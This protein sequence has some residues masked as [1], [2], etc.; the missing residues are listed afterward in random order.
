VQ[1]TQVDVGDLPPPSRA[2]V[3]VA[4][5]VN[6]END[7]HENQQIQLG[8]DHRVP[9]ASR[10]R[11][12]GQGRVSRRRGFSDATFYKW[13]A[14]YGGMDAPNAKRLGEQVGENAKL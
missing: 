13:R 10:A 11:R 14:K 6:L 12:A 2:K 4:K 7:G 1:L 5:F 9:Q 8:T 3:K